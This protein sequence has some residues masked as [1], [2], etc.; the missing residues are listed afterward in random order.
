MVIV[1]LYN[2]LLYVFSASVPEAANV[3]YE[4]LENERPICPFAEDLC[5][6]L[7]IKILAKA[8]A[9]LVPMAVPCV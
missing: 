7:A 9:I 8:T 3:V 6:N 5:F 4:A 1:T 2:E